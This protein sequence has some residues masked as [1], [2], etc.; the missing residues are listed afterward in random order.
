MGCGTSSRALITK[1]KELFSRFGIPKT[2]V[3]D[4]DVK[5]KSNEFKQFCEM[6]GIRYVTSPIYHP[7]SNGQAENSVKTCKKMIKCIISDNCPQHLI[8]EKLLGFLF[9]YRTTPHCAT[10]E[11]PAKLMF[12]RN[13]TTRLD[14]L[15]K[16]SH[17]YETDSNNLKTKR[18]ISIGDRVWLKWYIARKEIWVLGKIIKLLGN[19]MFEILV[20]D[21]NVNCKRHCDQIRKYTG[22]RE[23][24][25][26]LADVVS[27]TQSAPLPPRPRSPPSPVAAPRQS[28]SCDDEARQGEESDNGEEDEWAEAQ[29]AADVNDNNEIIEDRVDPVLGPQRTRPIRSCRRKINYKV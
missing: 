24:N 18:T 23:T 19:R 6:N 2:I 28:L 29:E 11:C 26:A 16:D 1:L 12:G 13:I 25:G 20:K 15:L 22:P 4:N 9:E 21:Y 7:S 3:S 5:I 17:N 14:L 8:N 10:G 27:S